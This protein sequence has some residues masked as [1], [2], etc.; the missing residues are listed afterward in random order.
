MRIDPCDAEFKD[1]AAADPANGVWPSGNKTKMEEQLKAKR[2]ILALLFLNYA[3]RFADLGTNGKLPPAPKGTATD[4][5]KAAATLD[6]YF[7]NWFT[8]NFESTLKST[9]P[10]IIDWSKHRE[11]GACDLK[12]ILREYEQYS[13][14]KI[15]G[16]DAIA[17][18]ERLKF[19]V[20]KIVNKPFFLNYNQ[21]VAARRMHAAEE[22]EA[23]SAP[24]AAHP[25]PPAGDQVEQA[26]LHMALV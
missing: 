6:N 26:M 19:T 14:Q 12:Y 20:K 16:K 10:D 17:T 15:S 4:A 24:A 11:D 8:N 21:G 5:L 23:P 9:Q 13:G 2:P 18:L 7:E 22:V 1:G 3:R 25:P